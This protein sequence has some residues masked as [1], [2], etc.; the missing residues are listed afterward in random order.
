MDTSRKSQS[1]CKPSP[2]GELQGET[3]QVSDILDN[4]RSEWL[5]APG[6]MWPFDEE[7]DPEEVT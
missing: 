7:H 5:A 6:P 1:S 4:G 3:I 2:A